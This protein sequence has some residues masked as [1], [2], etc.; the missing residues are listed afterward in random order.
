MH[1]V[2]MMESALSLQD[3]KA[4]REVVPRAFSI[5]NDGDYLVHYVELNEVLLG[6]SPLGDDFN[7]SL[8]RHNLS[9]GTA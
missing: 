7:N 1:T 9:S 4:L 2:K 5:G 6:Q 8:D 3:I